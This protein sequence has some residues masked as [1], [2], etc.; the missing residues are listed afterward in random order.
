MIVKNTLLAIALCVSIA[1]NAQLKTPQPSPT[2]TISQVVGLTDVEVIY[3]RPGKKERV[4]YGDVVP[5]DKL[6]RTGANK[7]TQL[8]FST[9]VKLEGNDVKAGSYSLFTIPGKEEWTIIINSNTEL[10]GAGGYKQDEDIVRFT[11]EPSQMN[12]VVESFTIDFGNFKSG[13]AQMNLSWENTKIS[14]KVETGAIEAVEKQ[15]KEILVDGP[16]AGTYYN[17]TRFYLDNDKDMKQALAWINVAIDKRPEAFWYIYQKA[18]VQ[19]KLGNTKEAI[20]TAEKSLKMAQ[21][22]E[23]GDYGYVANNEKLIAELKAK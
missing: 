19:G 22:N 10:W 2:A 12:D 9:D 14:I 11:V 13:E 7:A 3:S 23:E 4:V 17:A 8:T 18:R 15:I 6:W 21:E 16:G 20:A 5:Y 1:S